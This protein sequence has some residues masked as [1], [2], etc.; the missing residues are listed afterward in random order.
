MAISYMSKFV[1]LY[2]FDPNYI[3]IF[4]STQI[5]KLDIIGFIKQFYRETWEWSVNFSKHE[6]FM[7]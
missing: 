1:Q 7:Q 6:F 3:L 4:D 2:L 5:M